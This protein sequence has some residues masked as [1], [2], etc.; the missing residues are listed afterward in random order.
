M[1]QEEEP[2]T[3]G[4]KSGTSAGTSAGPGSDASPAAGTGPD[5]DPRDFT[6]LRPWR[7]NARGHGRAGEHRVGRS[8]GDALEQ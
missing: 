6:T 3:N 4:A 7:G 5:F 2:V 1:R 8:G